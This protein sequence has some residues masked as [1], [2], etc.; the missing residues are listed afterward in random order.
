MA[1]NITTTT[2]QEAYE[3]RRALLADPLISAIWDHAEAM[4]HLNRKDFLEELWDADFT[5]FHAVEICDILFPEP[6]EIA[7]D[8]DNFAWP[9]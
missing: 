9:F 7:D 6:R 3:A 4:G 1:A 8:F 2:H 5:P